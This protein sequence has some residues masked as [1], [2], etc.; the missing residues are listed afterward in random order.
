MFG[1]F[2]FSVLT[3]WSI[4]RQSI[5]SGAMGLNLF[6]FSVGLLGLALALI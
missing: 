5:D 2:F 4:Y 6:G 3:V 1:M